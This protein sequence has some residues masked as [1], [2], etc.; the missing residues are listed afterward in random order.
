M[1]VFIIAEA[2]VNHNG[3]YDLACKLALEAKKAGADAVK[4][5]TFKAEALVTPDADT[6]GYQKQAVG[7]SKSQYQMLKSLE[8]T[9]EEFMSLRHYC[10]EIGI[11][12]CSTTFD[13]L[14]TTFAF[15][16]LDLPFVKIP[17]GE[18]TNLPFLEVAGASKKPVILSTGA[19]SL[20]EVQ[21]AV[22][23]LK[24]AGSND[25]TVLH[26]TTQYPAPYE[27]VDLRAMEAMGKTLGLPYGYSD[28]TKGIEVAVA[29]VAMGA[30]VIEKHFTLNKTMEGPDHKASL[31]PQ[32]LSELI[33]AIRHVECA[34]GKPEK[35][36]HQ[37]ELDNRKVVRKSI[38]ALKPIK[39]GEIFS[40]DNIGT[41]R[42]GT[43][44]SPMCWHEVLGKRA[45][46][47]FD[48]NELIEL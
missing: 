42:P 16:K 36:I 3:S 48:A 31:E 45:S 10:D 37:S 18:I 8:L 34:L 43:G 41:K 46:R 27:D 11:A 9:E 44:I 19:C 13:S 6:A 17:S 4:Y 2:G 14:S 7:A 35:T 24:R 30:S 33:A 12:F 23:V 28:H 25:I 39:Q 32:E 38:V 40:E 15:D 5:Q 29:A 21:D 1:S 22:D 47:D 20:S 26:C